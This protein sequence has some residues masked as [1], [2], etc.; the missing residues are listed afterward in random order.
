LTLG[1]K[2]DS[3]GKRQKEGGE[4]LPKAHEHDL[5]EFASRALGFAAK[6]VKMGVLIS[7]KEML[8][9]CQI[10]YVFILIIFTMIRA[11]RK[12]EIV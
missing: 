4:P 8:C 3:E 2:S 7:G 9:Q 6:K 11:L 1:A 10:V 12:N 5:Q